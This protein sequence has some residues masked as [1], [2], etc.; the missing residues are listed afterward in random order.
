MQKSLFMTFAALGM[1][2]A[3]VHAAGTVTVN[4]STTV[5][6]AMQLVTENFMSA[7]PDVTVRFRVRVP[8]MASRRSATR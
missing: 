1:M 8:A 7:H 2:T 4:G 6:P 3:T 5:L